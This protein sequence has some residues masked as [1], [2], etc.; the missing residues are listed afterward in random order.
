MNDAQAARRSRF[1]LF[2]RIM[3]SVFALVLM[4]Y[5]VTLAVL[6]LPLKERAQ[7]YLDVRAESELS[8][9]MTAIQD[10]VLLR[11]YP[12]IEQT[13]ATRT[14]HSKILGVRFS[15]PHVTLESRTSILPQHYPAWF[16]ELIDIRVPHAESEIKVGGTSYGT[17]AVELDAGPTIQSL[18]VLIVRFTLLAMGSLLGIMLI[19]HWLLRVNLRG[20]YALR[21]AARSIAGG[22]FNARASLAYGS[23]PE[24]RETNLAFNSMADHVSSLV[25]EL[26]KEHY[27][28]LVEKERLRVTIESIGDAVIVTDA[29]GL[30]EFINP[31]AEDL[32]GFNSEDAQGRR[33]SDVLPLINEETGEMVTCPLDLALR[34][35]AVVK[36]DSHTLIRRKNGAQMAISDTAAPIRSS[37]GK[38]S[39]RRAGFSGR[40]RAAQSDAAF[41]LAG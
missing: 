19:L 39:G 37:D 15:T 3:G 9:I 38:S 1:S 32:T 31:R 28:L 24:V 27:D 2:T 41:G 16:S 8:A 26:E 23:P 4:M 14:A 20:L 5:L 29:N 13:F 33:V 11:D 34:N 17:L 21:T 10:H 36:L 6:G 22:D 35:N 30:I 12:A 18:W 40:K 7:Q 25:A